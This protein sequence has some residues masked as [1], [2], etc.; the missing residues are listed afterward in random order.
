[1]T[2][3]REASENFAM[4]V[5]SLQENPKLNQI[6]ADLLYMI[7]ICFENLDEEMLAFKNFQVALKLRN[8]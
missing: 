6:K 3:Y 5:E 7:G 2:K 1:M 8:K 4:V